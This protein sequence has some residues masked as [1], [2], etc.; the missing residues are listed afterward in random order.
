MHTYPE[1]IILFHPCSL[2]A[3]EAAED[4]EEP[5]DE[6]D[7]FGEEEDEFGEYVIAVAVAVLPFLVF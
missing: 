1:S 4:A 6:F 3:E 2:Q 7:E 5:Q